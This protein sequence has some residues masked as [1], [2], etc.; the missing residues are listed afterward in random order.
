M[1][2]RKQVD[3]A[4]AHDLTLT[5][6]ILRL[7]S[8]IGWRRSAPA[9]A[10]R[11][12]T[13]VDLGPIAGDAH[14]LQIPEILA[15]A[16]RNRD[17]VVDLPGPSAPEPPV[18]RERELDPTACATAPSVVEDLL[19]PIVAVGSHGETPEVV[20]DILVPSL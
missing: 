9:A 15:P 20:F 10:G 8:P 18:V 4:S 17:P 3:A 2:T 7:L 1:H 13:S 11:T 16:P 5:S 12:V 6:Y 14:W 19:D